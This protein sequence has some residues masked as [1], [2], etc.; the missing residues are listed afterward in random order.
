MVMVLETV[1]MI[2]VGMMVVVVE[3]GMMVV[4]IVLIVLIVL[5]EETLVTKVA[6]VG[7]RALVV[8]VLE[9]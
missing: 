9:A 4:V 6:S 1:G 2:G 5:M 7:V 3:V 8:V